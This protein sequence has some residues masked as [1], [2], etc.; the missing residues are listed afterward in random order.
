VLTI[1]YPDSAGFAELMKA[2]NEDNGKA[3]KPPDWRSE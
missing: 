3:L 1:F 2:D